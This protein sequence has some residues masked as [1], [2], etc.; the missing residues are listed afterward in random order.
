VTDD[1]GNWELPRSAANICQC[2][3]DF[4]PCAER[5]Y[6]FQSLLSLSWRC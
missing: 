5:F 4:A 2:E 6:S 1:T 3:Y